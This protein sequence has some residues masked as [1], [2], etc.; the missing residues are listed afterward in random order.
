MTKDPANRPPQ[1]FDVGQSPGPDDDA[2]PEPGKRQPRPP[3]AIAD[4]ERIVID[5][6]DYF[7][8]EHLD[9]LDVPPP[10]PSAA[11]RRGVRLGAIAWSAFG[12]IVALALGLWFDG[13]VRG[14][15][16][17]NALIGQAAMVAVGVFGLAVVALV[18][19]ELAAIWKLSAVGDLRDAINKAR[20]DGNMRDLAAATAR[21][22]AHFA[23]HPKAAAGRARLDALKD[24]IID[25]EDR[26][27]LVETELMKGLDVEARVL[28]MNSAKRVSVVTAVSPRALVDVGYVLYENVRLMRVI[29]EHYGGRTGFFGTLT[30]VRRVVTHLAVTGT[31][32]LG[33]GLVQQVVGQGLAARLSARL[34][35]GVVNGLLTARIGLAA[36]DVCRPSPFIALPRP[37]LADFAAILTRFSSGGDAGTAREG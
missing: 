35:E 2:S 20:D 19:R 21:L 18:V 6:D 4:P 15:L 1:A 25:P 28:V 33:D 9:E 26:L 29:A 5:E 14:L 11:R 32:A 31:I 22:E 8:R 16:E 37:R 24:D 27:A 7:A 13:L 34:G 17:R 30:L 23:R 36:I 12:A 3:V 10:R